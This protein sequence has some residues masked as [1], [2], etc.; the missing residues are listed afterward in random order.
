MLW[1]PGTYIEKTIIGKKGVFTVDRYVYFFNL[2]T[3]LQFHY[4]ANVFISHRI[5]D[6]QQAEAL[7]TEI[8]DANHTVWLDSWEIGIG[9]SIISKMNEGLEGSTYL[10]LCYSEAGVMAPWISQEW[11]TSLARKLNGENI[12]ILP[13]LLTGGKPPAILADIRYADLV[14]DWSKG[15]ADLLRAIR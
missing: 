1:N 7:A 11:M 14:A 8:R 6:K 2:A 12:K 9:D 15:I 10:I 4:M 5:K 13:A 3:D